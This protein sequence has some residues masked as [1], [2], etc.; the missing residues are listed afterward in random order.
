[1]FGVVLVPVAAGMFLKS[2]GR[3]ASG[4]A[5]EGNSPRSVAGALDS[6]FF[7]P[8]HN[9]YIAYRVRNLAPASCVSLFSGGLSGLLGLGG[10]VMHVPVMT[11]MCGVPMKA[12]AATSNFLIGVSAAAS[13]FIYFRRGYLIPDLAAVIIV[14]VLLGSF[15]G[16]KILYK[17]P[18]RKIQAVFAVFVF[19]VAVEMLRKAL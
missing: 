18:A 7:D 4:S 10:G 12:A 8:A 3:T 11:L 16:I 19:I 17:A 6:A 2:R 14:G 13:A 5:P 9:S 1:M 15:A